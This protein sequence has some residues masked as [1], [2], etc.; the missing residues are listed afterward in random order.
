MLRRLDWV[1]Q[2]LAPLLLLLHLLQPLPYACVSAG[3]VL[4][5]SQKFSLADDGMMVLPDALSEAQLKDLNAMVDR[6]LR[7]MENNTQALSGISLSKLARQNEAAGRMSFGSS[8]NSQFCFG[9]I[10]TRDPGKY[11]LRI[12]ELDL[13]PPGESGRNNA[14]LP[15]FIT[16]RP[17]WYAM[18]ANAL[19]KDAELRSATVILSTDRAIVTNETAQDQVGLPPTPCTSAP[20]LSGRSECTHTC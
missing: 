20:S 4:D 16:S 1:Q 14:L 2:L 13:S 17:R 11:E 5:P 7:T 9:D 10:T 18:V 12:P 6:A 19:G 15:R 8:A 3:Q